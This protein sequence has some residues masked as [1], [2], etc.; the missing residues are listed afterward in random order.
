MTWVRIVLVAVLIAL[1]G[2]DDDERRQGDASAHL[3]AGWEYYRTAEYRPA[4]RE[5][6]DALRAAPAGSAEHLQ[7]LYGLATTLDLGRPD[8]DARR[9]AQL[10]E[11]IIGESPDSDL[12]GWSTLALARM[13]ELVAGDET[14]DRPA[15]AAAYQRVID[16]Y[17]NH[18]AA[19]EA[20]LHQ[21]ALLANTLRPDDA[22]SARKALQNFIDTHPRSPWRS[23]FYSEIAACCAVLND[24]DAR[25]A[26]EIKALET[27]ERDPGNPGADNSFAYWFI[28]TLA[29]YECGDLETA[30]KYYS[31][32]IEEY[33]T[34]LR[35][36]SA[37]L[38][39]KRLE[40][41]QKTSSLSLYS[42]GSRA[43]VGQGSGRGDP[44]TPNIKLK[45]PSP[46]PSP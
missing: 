46:P 30:R 23:A 17:P 19:E 29:E 14:I 43:A 28:A 3:R 24:P 44:R 13:K 1:I 18:P 10:Y 42:G 26:A 22:R 12:A 45:E 36:Y 40:G 2:C 20:L 8:R 38:A 39:M 41:A 27:R 25:L 31:K 7:S 35:A 21:Q 4:A 5:F 15:A 9:A 11:Q 37:K 6:A 16:R 34:D 33:P 32:F